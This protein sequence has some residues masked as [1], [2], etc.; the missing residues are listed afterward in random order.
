M[1]EQEEMCYIDFSFIRFLFIYFIPNLGRLKTIGT[2]P[3]GL[4]K[5]FMCWIKAW[6]Q[7]EVS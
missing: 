2:H 5:M 6:R 1:A 3:L 7:G 4:W